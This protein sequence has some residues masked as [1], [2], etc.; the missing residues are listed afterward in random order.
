MFLCILHL[1]PNKHLMNGSPVYWGGQLH[2]GLWFTTWQIAAIPQVPGH[3]S[4][5]FWLTQASFNGHSE[6]TIHSGRQAGGLPIYPGT[7][8]QTACPLISL[9]WLLGPQGEGLQGLVFCGSKIQYL[10]YKIV[11]M[12][13][14][15]FLPRT[16]EQ[17]INALP[18]KPGK[19]LH[20]GIW[21][22]TLHSAFWPH[23][24]G[25]GSTHLF[26]I[27]ALSLG[28]SEFKTHSGLQPL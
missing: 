28:Q 2:I 15:L 12:A 22:I 8:E 23:V 7:Q 27:Q 17:T 13:K 5:H 20:I 1:L 6:L 26:R 18:E 21:L 11:I 19:Q 14:L 4:I 9:H 3:G 24:P 10:L 16:G 25:Q